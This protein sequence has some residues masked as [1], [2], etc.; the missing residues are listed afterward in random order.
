M[1]LGAKN[2]LGFVNGTLSQPK[3]DD[4]SYNKWVRNDYL[5][6]SWILGSIKQDISQNLMYLTSSKELWDEIKDRY[7]QSNAPL[8]YQLKKDLNDLRQANQ[9]VAEYYCKPKSLWDEISSI[10]GVPECTCGALKN[11]TFNILKKLLDA[12]AL[13]KLMQFLMALNDGYENMRGNVLAMDPLPPVNRA[14]HLVQQ[15]EK[16]KQVTGNIQAEAESSALSVGKQTQGNW[17]KRETKEEKMK[18]KCEHSL[19]RG[20]LKDQCF[21]LVG[22]PEWFTKPKGKNN[23]RPTAANVNKKVGG[24]HVADSPLEKNSEAGECSGT[25]LDATLISSVVQE[26]M[27]AIGEKQATSHFAGTINSYNMATFFNFL[28]NKGWIIDTGASDHMRGN[29]NLFTDLRKLKKEMKVGLPDGTLRNV[30]EIGT[31][32]IQPGIKLENYLLVPEFRQNLLSVSKLLEKDKLKIIFDKNGCLIQDLTSDEKIAS[33]RV[34]DGLYKLEDLKIRRSFNACNKIDALSSETLSRRDCNVAESLSVLHS[35]LGHISLSKMKDLS[36]CNCKGVSYLFCDTCGVAKHHRLP[37]TISSSIAS[38]IFDLIH[39]DLWGP[40]RIHTITGASYFFTIVDDHSRATWTYLLANK[41][42]V[43]GILRNFLAYVE[44][45]FDKKVK[46]IRSDNGTEIV[47]SECGE[48]MGEKGILHQKSVA[49]VPQQNGRVEIK[50]GF[51]L[52]RARAMKIH[53]G[54]PT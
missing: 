46:T 6:S 33:G 30:K 21:K 29:R 17:Q 5:V 19:M 14:F 22:Y 48:L 2:K 52:E 34:E 54:L 45:H 35:R 37:F 12:D 8:L 36:I 49:G 25:K 47:Q 11:C 32:Y 24:E 18:K 41:E 42:Q 43:R 44:N 27:K 23:Q 40:Y 50:D 16:Q 38:S 20:H 15:V 10:E 28:Q 7:G 9:S 4:A 39:V 3:P 53:A 31:V 51:L 26:V 13:N 1:A